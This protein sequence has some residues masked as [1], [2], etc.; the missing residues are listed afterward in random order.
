[1]VVCYLAVIWSEEWKWGIGN[2]TSKVDPSDAVLD[3][4]HRGVLV[5]FGGY[6]FGMSHATYMHRQA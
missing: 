4:S 1:M 5:R 6:A 3:F 2:E